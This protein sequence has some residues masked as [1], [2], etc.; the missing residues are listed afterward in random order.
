MW[1]DTINKYRLMNTKDGK[2]IRNQLTES[3]RRGNHKL[4]LIVSKGKIH[5]SPSDKGNGIVIMPMDMY[6]KLVKIRTDK[7]TEVS[8]EDL[9]EIRSHSRSLAKITGLGVNEGEKN[10][11]SMW[12]LWRMP[13]LS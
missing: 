10:V 3:Q 9:E 12:K 1:I 7:D 2:Q 6:S 11:D 8:W 4:E 13:L 5:V